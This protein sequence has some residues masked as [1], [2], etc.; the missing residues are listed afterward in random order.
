M[1]KTLTTTTLLIL[2]LSG[3]SLNATTER[4]PDRVPDEYAESVTL[5]WDFFDRDEFR[6]ERSAFAEYLASVLHEAGGHQV[7]V[8]RLGLDVSSATEVNFW[9]QLA[10]IYTPGHPGNKHKY[11]RISF[12]ITDK[13]SGDQN[14]VHCRMYIRPEYCNVEIYHCKQNALFEGF[15]K[16]RLKGFRD[17]RGLT[18]SCAD[19]GVTPHQEIADF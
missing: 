12:A 2:V 5:S 14:R 8:N 13:N 9:H 10:N 15:F 11:L 7:S 18:R 19:A 16:K 3:R 4:I 17:D 1:K 6:F